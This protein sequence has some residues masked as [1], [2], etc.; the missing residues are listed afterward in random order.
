MLVQNHQESSKISSQNP[1]LDLRDPKET[2]KIP[3]STGIVELGRVDIER[4]SPAELEGR[5]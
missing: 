2:L 3:R 5:R 1:F 4:Q